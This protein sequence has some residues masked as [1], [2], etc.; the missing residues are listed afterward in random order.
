MQT[1]RQSA[2]LA[3]SPSVPQDS[4]RPR[5]QPGWV[6]LVLLALALWLSEGRTLWAAWQSDP[7]LSQGPVV[8]VVAVAHL[9]MRRAELQRW[10]SADGGGLALLLVSAAGYV[11]GVWADIDFLKPLALIG[12]S[13]G[14]VWFLGGRRTFGAAAGALGFLAFM[15]PWPTTVTE[16]LAFPLQLLSSAY[17]AQFAG[18]LGVPIQREGV[19]L[20]VVP[21]LNA[22]PVY[23]I[24]V[25]QA[26]SGLTSLVVLLA[27]GYLVAYH[28]PVR[29]GWRAL[30]VAV[31]VPLALLLNALRLTLVLVVGAGHGAGL[32]RWVHDHEEPVL[33]FLCSLCLLGLRH[34]LLVWIQSR[35][36]RPPASGAVRGPALVTVSA[37]AVR[38]P[39]PHGA[40]EGKTHA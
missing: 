11:A 14:A 15:I 5:W 27:L 12:V 8:C 26:C 21:H 36:E 19:N 31:V 20:A 35:E 28:T 7:S 3:A 6:T 29:W 4:W 24:T 10:R 32:A 33:V 38:D 39:A 40:G 23:A 37:A 17:A 1:L 34:L 22:P 30:L 2:S 18:M 25:A 13:V 9:W 16:R